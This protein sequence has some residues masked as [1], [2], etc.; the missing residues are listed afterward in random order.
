MADGVSGDFRSGGRGSSGTKGA[1]VTTKTKQY[2]GGG[3]GGGYYGGGGGAGCPGGGGSSWVHPKLQTSSVSYGT[4]A[5]TNPT[6]PPN[7]EIT[8]TY[9]TA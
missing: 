1:I 8:F 5:V 2:G 9:N 6:D 3:G 4:A 7:G